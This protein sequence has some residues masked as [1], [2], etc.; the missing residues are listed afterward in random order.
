M[1]TKADLDQFK[2][3]LKPIKQTV[4]IIQNKVS[5]IEAKQNIMHLAMKSMDDKI[6][7]LD[8]KVEHALKYAEIIE[9]EHEK[10]FKKVESKLGIAA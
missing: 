6:D 3:L 8:E 9:E 7:V 2:S 4:E 5:K 10:R 1:L